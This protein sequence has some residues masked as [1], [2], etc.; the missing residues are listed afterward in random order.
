MNWSGNVW[1]N[2]AMELKMASDRPHGG[3]RLDGDPRAGDAQAQSPETAIYS[4][5][6]ADAAA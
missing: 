1:D 5:S 4:Y 2:A 3:Q 6:A